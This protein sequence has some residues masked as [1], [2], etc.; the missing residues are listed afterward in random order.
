MYVEQSMSTQVDTAT[1]EMKISQVSRLMK[2]KGRRYL[3]V[4]DGEKLVFTDA[5][6]EGWKPAPDPF[7]TAILLLSD[8]EGGG[9]TYTA[10]ARHRSPESRKV[11]EDMGFYSGWGTVVDQLEEYAATLR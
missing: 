10:I 11:H 5:Y 8:A 3:P 1:E 4:V 9:T 6:T 2:E 7:M